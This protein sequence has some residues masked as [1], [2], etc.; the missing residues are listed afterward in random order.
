MT[1]NNI[2]DKL[3]LETINLSDGDRNVE[4]GYTGDLLSWVMG[5]AESGNAWITIMSNVNIL[6]V[7]ALLDFSCIILAENA[8]VSEEL[9]TLAAQKRI[10]LLRSEKSSYKLCVE[11]GRLQ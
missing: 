4:G 7:A 8:D 1:V 10:N 3:S 9:R 5:R 11:L 2:I 6:A